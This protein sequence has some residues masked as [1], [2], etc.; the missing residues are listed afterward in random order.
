MFDVNIHTSN[1][2]VLENNTFLYDTE[3][4]TAQNTLDEETGIVEINLDFCSVKKAICTDVQT[5]VL[6]ALMILQ[7]FKFW[8]ERVGMELVT[9][10]DM[11]FSPRLPLK[12]RRWVAVVKKDEKEK[13]DRRGA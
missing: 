7:K 1:R 11:T 2:H 10:Y 6:N 13:T 4:C 5:N 12:M 3:M 8:L 9:I